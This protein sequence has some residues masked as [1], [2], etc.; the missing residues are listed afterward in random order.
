[1]GHQIAILG[2]QILKIYLPNNYLIMLWQ[3]IVKQSEYALSIGALHPI[4]TTNHYL[5]DSG[6]NFIVRISSTIE[7]KKVAALKQ[8]QENTNPFLP[9]EKDLF[10]EDLSETHFCLLNKYNVVEHHILIITKA[11]EEQDSLL[12][13]EDFSALWTCLSQ[14]DGLGFY[15]GGKVAGASQRHKHLQ[16]V[17]IPILSIPT[18]SVISAT[19]T[20]EGITSSPAF[21]FVH[22]LIHFELE[23]LPDPAQT[24]LQSYQALLERIGASP[25]NLLVT[26]RWM[27]IVPRSQEKSLKI[28]INSLGFAGCFFV[29]NQEYFK[30]L[31]DYGPL[32]LL[33]DVGY[34]T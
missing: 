12:T 11:F 30:K 9:H 5:Q 19:L 21:P 10:V 22:A 1:M 23:Q 17:P 31:A 4:P 7:K 15:N 26:N 28:S 13:L 33:R 3:K 27:L 29:K 18:Q 24:L 20:K 25:Y 14:I 6:I 32:N 34:S 2:Y 16:L 8:Q